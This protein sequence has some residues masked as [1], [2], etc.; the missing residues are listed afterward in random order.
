MW[1]IPPLLFIVITIDIS[2][3]KLKPRHFVNNMAVK[4]ANPPVEW[5]SS[6]LLVSFHLEHSDKTFHYQN[7]TT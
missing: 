3:Y 5:H 6:E 2:Q 4:Y 1:S 7:E